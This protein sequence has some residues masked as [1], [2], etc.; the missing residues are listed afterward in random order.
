MLAASADSGPPPGAVVDAGPAR[1]LPSLP[2]LGKTG[3]AVLESP[4]MVD[5]GESGPLPLVLSPEMVLLGAA[6]LDS[7]VDGADEGEDD[8]TLSL[9]EPSAFVVGPL[10]PIPG[11]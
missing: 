10:A 3:S 9:D 6:E 11:K 7:D 5:V 1:V 4:A 2:G 8:E